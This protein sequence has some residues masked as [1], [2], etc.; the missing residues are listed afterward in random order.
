M[1][2]SICGTESK[3]DARFCS[4]CGATLI[5][6]KTDETM[7]DLRTAMHRRPVIIPAASPAPESAAPARTPTATEGVP[8]RAPPVP[9]GA[10]AQKSSRGGLIL[11]VIAVGIIGYFLYEVATT[12]GALWIDALTATPPA[13]KATEPSPPAPSAL[14]GNTATKTRGQE[15]GALAP[16]APRDAPATAT[17]TPSVAP[18][19]ATKAPPPAVSSPPKAASA[20]TSP[21]P[22]PKSTVATPP[23]PA[24]KSPSKASERAA[25]PAAAAMSDGKPPRSDRWQDMRDA[26]G[27][28]ARENLISRVACEQR[29]LYLYCSGYWGKVPQCPDAQNPIPAR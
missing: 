17:A 27:R 3:V 6:P 28:C 26:R 11:V 12:F 2:C 4:G 22:A 7:L 1:K 19:Q 25:S 15:V 9:G 20:S 14:A 16:A 18:T 13:T 21:K 5:L 24:P 23:S 29:V 8:A 10:P